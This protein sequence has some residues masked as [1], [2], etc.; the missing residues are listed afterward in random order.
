[1]FDFQSFYTDKFGLGVVV[2]IKDSNTVE[3]D[4]MDPI[5]VLILL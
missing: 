5:K 4:K 1:M 3:R 2:M